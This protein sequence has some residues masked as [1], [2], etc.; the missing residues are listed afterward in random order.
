MVLRLIEIDEH[1][2]PPAV[3]RLFA[4]IR[5]VTGRP[6][7]L[8]QRTLA[9]RP[10]A[11][12]ATWQELR[13]GFASGAFA[14]AGAALAGRA[15]EPAGPDAAPAPLAADAAPVPLAPDD[16]VAVRAVLAFFT[17][18]NLAT[19]VALAALERIVAGTARFA[20]GAELQSALAPLRPEPIVPPLAREAMRAD[21]RAALR[22]LIA[23][24]GDT[25]GLMPGLY[26]HL[27]R[28]P[29]LVLAVAPAL[30]SRFE[31][32]T[33]ARQ[34]AVLEVEARRAAAPLL[35]EN[36]VSALVLAAAD[37]AYAE[38]AIA[39]FQEKV[40]EMLVVARLLEDAL[41]PR[42]AARIE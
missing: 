10:A 16:A 29:E 24:S 6:P 28:W 13:P 42:P 26:R 40:A 5:A 3:A 32:G 33:I 18:G 15:P 14:A 4:D 9:A 41:A 21:V 27:A 37:R 20:P 22:A 11:L 35:R 1:D 23:R 25:S 34:V 30:G 31:D 7:N 12:R 36:A 8:F 38:A 17:T 19:A 39:A 2:A